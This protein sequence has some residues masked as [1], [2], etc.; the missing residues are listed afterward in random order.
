MFSILVG[1]ALK[2]IVVLAAARIV[3]LA[4]R[5]CSAA[6]RHLVWSG[7]LA[8]LLVLPLLS[9]A[10][11]RL[12][13]P[14]ALQVGVTFRTGAAVPAAQT[15]TAPAIGREPAPNAGRASLS[16]TAP[17]GIA[18]SFV[19]LLLW[20]A[21]AAIALTQMVLA[22]AALARRRRAAQAFPEGG[23]VRGLA[24]SLGIARRVDVLQAEADTMPMTFGVFRPAVLMPAG[25][26]DWD[27]ERRRLVLL[28]ELAHVRR[29][30][31]ASHLLARFALALHWWNP[32]A[33]T[34]WRE[35]L[36]ERERATD[37]LVLNA[38]ARASDYAGHLLELARSLHA[39]TPLDCAAIAMARPSQLEGR[40]LAI[41]DG[42]RNR[43]APRRAPALAAALAAIALLAPL[44]A[45][46]AQDNTPL[47]DVDATIRAATL[48]KN[49][50]ILDHAAAAYTAAHQLAAAERLLQTSAAIREQ[51]SGSNSVDYG[52]GLI[53]LGN[54]ERQRNSVKQA[55]DFYTK[56]VGVLGDRPEAAPALLFLGVKTLGEVPVSK[57]SLGRLVVSMALPLEQSKLDLA[58]DYF[59]RLERSDPAQTGTAMMWLALLRE[60]AQNYPE[61]DK[62]FQSALAVENDGRQTAIMHRVYAAYLRRQGRTDDAAAQDQAAG[63]AAAPSA[64]PATA[65]GIYRVGNGT[66][67]PVMLHK[68]EPG[69]SE[70]ARVAQ[71]QGTVVLY[72]EIGTDGMAHNI[73]VLRSLGMGLDDQAIDAVSQWQFKPGTRNGVPVPVAATIEVNFRLL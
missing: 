47:P 62:L 11:P 55:V 73:Q 35:F 16:R 33:W 26:A 2:G 66:S 22:Y 58:A 60:R 40:L 23:A 28:H 70:E 8:A 20:A 46:Q 29:G 63:A 54:L 17:A 4:M 42:N 18:W 13:L 48:Q 41:L 71:Y 31:P 27:A 10:L 59:Q 39:P 19:L 38:G 30:D 3:T 36:K 50:E 25:S 64:K 57:N 65:D 1:A 61:A 37:D 6:S 67:A 21:G 43:R 53:K 56:A 5:R 15:G 9:L 12:A 51:V 68:T 32:L 45:V 34:A 69:Y 52:V 72:V 49:H 44:A 24:Q 7:A 14:P